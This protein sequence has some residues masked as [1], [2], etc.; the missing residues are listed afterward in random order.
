MAPSNH[1]L[2][3]AEGLF[4][5]VFS[6]NIMSGKNVQSFFDCVLTHLLDFFGVWFC[7]HLYLKAVPGLPEC[8]R[9]LYRGEAGR[10]NSIESFNLTLS[11]QYLYKL[12]L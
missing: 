8:Q 4:G 11:P 5:G 10:L 3:K 2:S 1:G 9:I 12:K 6:H 7:V